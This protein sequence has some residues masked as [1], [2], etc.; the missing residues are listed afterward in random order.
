MFLNTLLYL[1]LAIVGAGVYR[2]FGMN[3]IG[4][5]LST[6]NDVFHID[7][8]SDVAAAMTDEYADARRF[9][10]DIALWRILF[11]VNLRTPC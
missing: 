10:C 2:V 5:F 8:R 7:N 4:K 6:F 1:D 3:D 11:R 9:V